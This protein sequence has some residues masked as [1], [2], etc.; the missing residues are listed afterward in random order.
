[1][2]ILPVLFRNPPRLLDQLR[3]AALAHFGRPEPGKR[4]A[5]LARKYPRAAQEFGWPFL[6][7]S[8]QRSRAPKT[9]DIGR[10]LVHNG[11]LTRA[12]THA[13]RR[14]GLIR[15]ANP[16]TLRHSRRGEK[17]TCK[18]MAVY[19]NVPEPSAQ[20]DNPRPSRT[21]LLPSTLANSRPQ[22]S[23]Y[24]EGHFPS[25]KVEFATHAANL[26]DSGQ[27]TCSLRDTR[28]GCPV[29]AEVSERGN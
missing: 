21:S 8:R 20:R 29:F 5:A 27:S 17:W 28:P 6:F 24:V 2:P 11:A 25:F 3:Q 7:V 9:G 23:K 22:A 26:A 12:V 13:A 15:R 16:K 18:A 10:H 4:F 1:M 19:D 14:A